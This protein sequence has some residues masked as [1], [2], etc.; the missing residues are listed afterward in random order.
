MKAAL[1]Y[2]NPRKARPTVSTRQRSETHTIPGIDD[3]KP[4]YQ[5]QPD[6]LGRETDVLVPQ[7]DLQRHVENITLRELNDEEQICS[8]EPRRYAERLGRSML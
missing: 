4:D 3:L 2:S 5:T 6:M 7:D 1:C 8:T